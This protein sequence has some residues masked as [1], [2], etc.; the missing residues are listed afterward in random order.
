MSSSSPR[1]LAPRRGLPKWLKITILGLLVATTLGALAIFWAL[2]TGQGVLARAESDDEVVS[3]LSAANGSTLTFLVVG[4]DSRERLDDIA[5]FGKA[6]GERGDV[7]MLVHLDQAAGEARML[8]IP[9]DLWVDIPGHGEGKINAAYSYGGSSLM[10]Q[11]IRENLGIEVNHYVEVDF[12]GFIEMVDQL[13]GIEMTFPY[14]A[15]DAN[16]GLSV[17]AGTQTLDG[18]QALAFARSRKYEEFQNDRWVS[19]DASDLGR[20]QRQQ[21]VVRAILT[22][23]K[24][25][26]SIAEAGQI[27]GSMAEHM[28]IDATLA[29]SSVA[30]MAWDFQGLVTGS[31]DGQTLPVYGDTVNGASVVMAAEPEASTM[32]DGFLTGVETVESA[33]LRVQVLNGNGIAGAASAMSERLAGSGFE[34][35]GLGNAE[36]RDYAT[37]TIVVP[38]GSTA[39][40]Q[41]IGQIGFGVV[42]IGTVDKGYDAVV[43][44]GADAS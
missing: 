35:V 25:P 20:T 9:R 10:V 40:D 41:I 32:I 2:N 23:M 34:I 44:V 19:V 18:E 22:E 36:A 39:G 29:T 28:T 16:S 31:I 4:S 14:P 21:E 11:T 3:E 6:A 30:S 8:S 17:E 5:F 42:Q 7:I 27:A 1:H 15:R 12:V 13:G 38:D 43:I 33:P 26:A 37:T 24:T